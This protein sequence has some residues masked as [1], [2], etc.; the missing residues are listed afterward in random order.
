MKFN[1]EFF[2]T[3]KGILLTTGVILLSSAAA[4]I[5]CIAFVSQQMASSDEDTDM[6][7]LPVREVFEL[8]FDEKKTE[9]LGRAELSLLEAFTQGVVKKDYK[10]A[11]DSKSV[12]A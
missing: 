4:A 7:Q 11:H 9:L 6:P 2:T 5:G 12:F 8:V 1:W 3:T 10:K